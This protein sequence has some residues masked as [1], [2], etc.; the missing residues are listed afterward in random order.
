MPPLTQMNMSFGT[1]STTPPDEWEVFGTN[2]A[3]TLT[4]A[5]ELLTGTTETE[6]NLSDVVGTWK[7]LD[8]TAVAGNILINELDSNIAPAPPIGQ[9]L[10]VVLAVGG[11]LFGARLWQRSKGRRSLGPVMPHAAA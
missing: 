7:Y 4:G 10:P 8:V 3:G 2:T 11:L 5:T 6:Q 9:G 1:N